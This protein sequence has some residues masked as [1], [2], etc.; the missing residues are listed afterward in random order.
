MGGVIADKDGWLLDDLAPPNKKRRTHPLTRRLSNHSN[1]NHSNQNQF[2]QKRRS[3]PLDVEIEPFWNEDS[4]SSNPVLSITPTQSPCPLSHVLPSPNHSL[5]PPTQL[6]A[7]PTHSSFV[8]IKVR[9]DDGTFLVPCPW[10]QDDGAETTIGS[11]AE[12]A[13]DRYFHQH[14]RR[15]ILSLTTSEG[16]FLF[17]TDRLIEVLQEG[18]QVV[19][20]VKHW[21]TPPIAQHYESV[22]DRFK[23]S[24]FAS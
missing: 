7:P 11:L 5:A 1:Q 23:S 6:V 17:P 19:G 14:G 15:P 4:N 20:V 8:R 10:Q 12:A 16:A 13:S 21:E 2:T 22:C 3:N 9:L 18:D 24:R